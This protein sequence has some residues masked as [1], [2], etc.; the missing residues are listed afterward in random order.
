M[1]SSVAGLTLQQQSLPTAQ[2]NLLK[3]TQSLKAS[4]S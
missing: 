1:L 3:L 2:L 4:R